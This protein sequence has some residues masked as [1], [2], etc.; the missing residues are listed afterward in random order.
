MS[1][2]NNNSS[3]RFF[4]SFC[5]QA[6]PQQRR[7]WPQAP[8]GVQSSHSWGGFPALPVL[9]QTRICTFKSPVRPWLL[10]SPSL[11]V[12]R[13][14]PPPAPPVLPHQVGPIHVPTRRDINQSGCWAQLPRF[15]L[16]YPYC[17]QIQNRKLYFAKQ[18]CL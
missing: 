13:H 4:Q 16:W 9:S 1:F 7:R 18:K 15:E 6:T 12:T 5:P 10:V 14:P 2:P 11:G 3:S 17:V 8:P